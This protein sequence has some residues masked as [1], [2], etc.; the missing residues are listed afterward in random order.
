MWT[1]SAALLGFVGA[2]L[3]SIVAPLV[4]RMWDHHFDGAAERERDRD[5]SLD[6]I[7]TCIGKIIEG[8][9]EL[10]P[11]D[12][13]TAPMDKVTESRIIAQLQH[14]NMLLN[15]LFDP[16]SNDMIKSRDEWKCLHVIVTGGDF[17]EPT[18]KADPLRLTAIHLDALTLKRGITGRRRNLPRKL[19]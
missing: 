16:N 3:G 9:E 2:A 7:V 17:G 13:I 12:A 11:R 5:S 14:I 15:S 1:T 19:F 10:W 4:P 8:C 6:E 18:R